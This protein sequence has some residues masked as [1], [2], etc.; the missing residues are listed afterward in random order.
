MK[1]PTIKTGLVTSPS[2]ALS[3]ELLGPGVV[4]DGIFLSQDEFH[5]IQKLYG[6]KSEKNP[7]MQAGAIRNALREA[8]CDGLRMLAWLAKYVPAGEDPVK[9]LV[10]L[11]VEA[12]FDVPSEDIEWTET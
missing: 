9:T 6:Y 1:R 10:Q 11:A 5:S 8:S 4:Q 2:R 7:L 3:V 12:G